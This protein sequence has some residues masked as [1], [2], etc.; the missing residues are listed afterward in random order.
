MARDP[1][2]DILFEPIQIGPKTLPNRFYQVP[3]CTGAGS[4]KP[5]FQAANRAMKAEGGWGAVCTEY[6]SIHPESDDTMRVSARIWDEGDV[7]NLATM[8]R[9]VHEYNALAGIELWYG[10]AH[11]PSMESRDRPRGPSGLS[12]DFE[13]NSYAR[14]MDKSDIRTVQGYY[15]EAAKR[16]RRADFDIVYLYGAHTYGP[17]LFLS[18]FYNKRTDEYGGSFENR[19]RFWR[20]TLEMMKEAVGD[21]CAIAS[22]FS[23]DQLDGTGISVKEDGIR[24]IEHCDHLVDLWDITIG[25]IAE[26]GQDAGPSRFFPENHQKDYVGLIKAGGH[27][28]KP[29]VGVGRF[30]NPD[31]MADVINSGQ[32]DII[33][34]ARPSISDPFLPNKINEGRLEDI[35]ECIGCNMCISRWEIGG[36]PIICTQNATQGEEYRRG[37][38]PEKF[39]TAKNSDKGVLVV[40]AGPAGMECAMILG[41]RGVS[42]VHLV[43]ASDDIGGHLSWVSTLGHGDGKSGQHRGTARG[44]GDWHRVIDYRKIQLDKLKNVQVHTGSKLTADEIRKYGAEIV[45]I[46]TGARWATDGTSPQTRKPIPGA[47]PDTDWQLTPDEVALESKPVGKRVLVLETESYFM[48]VSVAQKLAGQGHDVTMVTPLPEVAQYMDFTLEAP[49]MHRELERLGVKI[50]ANTMVESLEPGKATL[51]KV[52][53]EDQKEDV[54]FDSVVLCTTRIPNDELYHE[55]QSDPEALK[56]EGI[57]QVHL[58]GDAAAPR[59]IAESIFDGHRLA[60]EIDSPNPASP[61]PFIRE[62]RLWGDSTNEQY[63]DQLENV[64]DTE[65]YR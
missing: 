35:R 52:W 20:E 41:K 59:V 29:V 12:S 28:K 13:V 46:A 10:G 37:W 55:L 65:V 21:D 32:L 4:E 45:I 53:A 47:S 27:T 16:A 49:M 19:A 64:R 40:G 39:H 60:R 33:G 54:L 44:L 58:I 56:E 11:A 2:H 1:K 63:E 8:T 6:C 5:G 23:I 22:R 61:L 25:G 3:H 31:T 26:W 30:T 36:P 57:E 17:L 62:R 9:A 18:P 14:A 34:A 7:R 15:V 38:H 24:L 42:D 48:G 51:Y 50:R 43:D